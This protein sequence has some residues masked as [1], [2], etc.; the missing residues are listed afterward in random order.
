MYSTI[1]A[2]GYLTW[3][4]QQ[5]I[6]SSCTVNVYVVINFCDSVWYLWLEANL[7]QFFICSFVCLFVYICIVIEDPGISDIRNV[8]DYWISLIDLMP[9]HCFPCQNPETWISIGICHL[10]FCIQWFEK[11]LKIP[12]RQSESVYIVVNFVDSGGFVDR[13]GLKFLFM[14]Y[15]NY[16]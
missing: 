4:I 3:R 9:P 7:C 16:S 8:K 14:N 15:Y 11:S 12:K 2:R 5:A 10:S 6:V 1:L 13:Q